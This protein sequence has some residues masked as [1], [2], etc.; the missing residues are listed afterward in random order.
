MIRWGP[1]KISMYDNVDIS[2][3]SSLRQVRIVDSRNGEG[4]P[5]PNKG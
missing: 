3:P 1:G 4:L 2:P 5:D